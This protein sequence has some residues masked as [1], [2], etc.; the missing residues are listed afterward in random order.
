MRCAWNERILHFLLRLRQVKHPV[1]DLLLLSGMCRTEGMISTNEEWAEQDKDFGVVAPR[2]GAL[3][4]NTHFFCR[5]TLSRIPP[6]HVITSM[7]TAER[8]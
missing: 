7:S 8:A 4:G 6:K 1:R 5:V 3:W 2:T